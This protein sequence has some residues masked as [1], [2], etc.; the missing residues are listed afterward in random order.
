[1]YP[2]EPD[3]LQPI[4]IKASSM[5]CRSPLSTFTWPGV[6]LVLLLLFGAC[7]QA[8][9]DEGGEGQEQ[10]TRVTVELAELSEVE[11]L[12]RSLGRLRAV[13]DI[14]VSAEVEGRLLEVLV[15]EGDEVEQGDLLATIDPLDFELQLSQGRA[16]IGQLEAEINTQEA[17]VQRQRQLREGGHVSE[18]VLEQSEA[19]LIALEQ[20]LIMARA[21]LASAQ[22]NRDRSTI[23]A[24]LSGRVGARYVNAGEYMTGGQQMFRIVRGSALEVELPF[25]ERLADVLEAGQ[26]V[27]LY[28]TGAD[29]SMVETQIK[30]ILP[31]IGKDNS[32][33]V[34]L[35]Q[36]DNPGNWR[37]GGSVH[38]EVV[39]DVHESVLVPGQAVVLRPEGE[40]VYLDEGGRAVERSVEI[41]R[42]TADWVE[43]RAGV[44]D[45]DRV[46][47]DGAGFLADGVLVEAEIRAASEEEM[48]VG[49]AGG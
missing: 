4:F 3:P 49:E 23:V 36:L 21:K 25:P 22:L 15:S 11:S 8:E 37:P 6:A 28:G 29:D 44:G 1:M 35:A 39:L 20:S 41:G 7:S 45:G 18:A 31:T 9:P 12:E 5:R 27:R 30:A 47:V 48:P 43:L 33:V 32:A 13:D 14:T 17:N 40:V 42:R 26:T 24:P 19:E 38:A 2:I 10:K 16:E 34:A 46:I